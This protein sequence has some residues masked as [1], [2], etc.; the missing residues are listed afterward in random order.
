MLQLYTPG[1]LLTFIFTYTVAYGYATFLHRDA[2][3]LHTSSLLTFIF[4]YTVA[5]GYD[6]FHTWMLQLLTPVLY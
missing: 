5:Y 1:S 4:T 3:T 6:T 2:A